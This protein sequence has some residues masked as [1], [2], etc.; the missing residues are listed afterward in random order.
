MDHYGTHKTALIR[1]WFAKLTMKQL[2]RGTFRIAPAQ[3]G[4][5]GVHRRAPGQSQTVVWTK[6][7]CEILASIARFAQRTACRSICHGGHDFEVIRKQFGD[8]IQNRRVVVGEENLG[9]AGHGVRR[10]CSAVHHDG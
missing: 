3:S 8:P 9:F 6:S 7:A 4:D 10:A 2:R 5:S 1:N